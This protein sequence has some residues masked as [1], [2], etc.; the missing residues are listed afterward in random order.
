MI[1]PT[2]AFVQRLLLLC[3]KDR[4]SAQDPTGAPTSDA[5]ARNATQTAAPSQRQ[6]PNQ[7][8]TQ[9]APSQQSPLDEKLFTLGML[10]YLSCTAPLCCSCALQKA[11]LE[12]NNCPAMCLLC[13]CALFHCHDTAATWS[14]RR[15]GCKTGLCLLADDLSS[16]DGGSPAAVK[17]ISSL[18]VSESNPEATKKGG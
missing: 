1:C 9:A 16:E 15:S 5:M 2:A 4:L 13:F 18:S 6:Q 14:C 7:A 11:Q 8:S 12:S 17:G 3:S 10:E